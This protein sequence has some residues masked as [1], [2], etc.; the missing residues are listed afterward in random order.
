MSILSAALIRDAVP[1]GGGQV[2]S[3]R[4]ASNCPKG[5]L[6]KTW[7]TRNLLRAVS[8]GPLF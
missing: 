4:Y 3:H 7:K 8:L 5:F 1:R 2:F 6:G